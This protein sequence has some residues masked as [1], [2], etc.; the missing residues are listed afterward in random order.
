MKKLITRFR[1]LDN[2]AKARTIAFTAS[3]INTIGTTT[4]SAVY[5][6]VADYTNNKITVVGVG[7]G[8]SRT[9]IL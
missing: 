7:R 8:G 9:I 6:I 1:A 5:G 3:L 4:E 2:A